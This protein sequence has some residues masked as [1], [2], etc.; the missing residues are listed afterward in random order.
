MKN[1]ALPWRFALLLFFASPVLLRAADFAPLEQLINDE[2]Q[3]NN[4]PG[5]AVAI[6]S[7]DKVIF[8]KGFGI[9]N[10]DT[11]QPVT[12]DMLFRLGSTTKMFTAAALV[13]LADEGKVKLDAPIGD[14]VPGLAPKLARVNS[15]QLLT[16]TAGLADLTF[17]EGPHDESAL[18][19][20]VRSLQD[21]LA[22][23]GPGAIY[24]Y[25]NPGYWL[26]GYVS[27]AVSGK[28][29]ADVVTERVL[30]PCG[31]TRSTFRPTAAMT[32]PLAVGHGPEG[33]AE[34]KVI[35]PLADNAAGWPAGQLFAT[36]PEFA[37]FCV[38]FMH[39]GKL[40]G[41][42]ALSPFLI[43]KLSAPHVETPGGE[44][45][46]GYGLSVKDENGV[47][48]L[49]HGG[50]RTGYG[51]HMRMCPEK[52][53][54]VII[55]CNKTGA[56]LMRVA[57][58]AVELVLGIAPERPAPPQKLATTAEEAATL[59]GVYTNG[60]TTIPL[61]AKDGKLT[62]PRGEVKRL[63]K[64]RFQLPNAPGSPG[65]SETTEFMV[66]TGTDGAQY[67]IRGGRAFKKR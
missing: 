34:P 30:K 58:K 66:V 3:R 51:S 36:A 19:N 43:E 29:Y 33:R 16:H 10:V 44:R 12:D 15:H 35:R 14:Y 7:G 4:V 61:T 45:H 8:S 55:L 49:S 67:L 47:R 52:K 65:A 27:E 5:C 46:Y 24:S 38:A 6:V 11:R 26:A 48:W 17:M 50:S 18:G 28:S 31:M 41:Q 1:P 22:F 63:G 62:T 60:R 64:N 2:L 32:W 25:S 54:A 56:S 40:D 42:T 37:R 9:A 21:S 20:N 13:S 39:G 23:T 59:A 53:F 57:D